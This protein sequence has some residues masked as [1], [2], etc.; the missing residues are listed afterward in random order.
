MRTIEA[1]RS[2]D[3]NTAVFWALVFK[4]LNKADKILALAIP[5]MTLRLT[6]LTSIHEDED[7]IPGL[8]QWVKCCHE[9]WCR[10][11]MQL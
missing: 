1:T 4:H 5:A 6:N 8:A 3:I 7:S 11:R 10:S 2:M 9:L